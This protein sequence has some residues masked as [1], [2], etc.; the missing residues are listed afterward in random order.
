MR[1]SQTQR[2]KVVINITHLKKSMLAAFV[3]LFVATANAQTIKGVVT[4]ADNG[5]P[6]IGATIKVK[7]TSKAA[8]TDMN[9]KYSI[10]GLTTGR[11]TIEASYIGYQ[12]AVIPEILVTE[13]KEVVIN[14][15]ISESMNELGELVV[16]PRISKESAVNKMALVG[17]RMLSMEEASRYAGGYS[18]PARLVTAFAGVAGNSNDNGVSVHGNARRPCSGDLRAWRSSARTTSPTPSTWAQDS[19]AHSTPMF[20]TTPTST[21]EPSQPSTAMPSQACLT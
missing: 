1:N 6:I 3:A 19:S 5:E 10:T 17:A 14:V 20:S 2:I 21:S 15:P 7:E 12:P 13:G 9:G 11:Y 8:V 16:K 18:D 4:D